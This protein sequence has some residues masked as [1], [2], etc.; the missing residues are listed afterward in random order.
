MNEFSRESRHALVVSTAPRVGRPGDVDTLDV[1]EIE[2]CMVGHRYS[3][4]P[5]LV[6][7]EGFSRPSAA[8]KARAGSRRARRGLRPNSASFGH[9][10]SATM[11]Q[12]SGAECTPDD[13]D[14]EPRIRIN[15]TELSL[16]AK[17][18]WTCPIC[19]SARPKGGNLNTP[20][21]TSIEGWNTTYVS[22]SSMA[23]TDLTAMDI[24]NVNS[25]RGD[26]GGSLKNDSLTQ[27]HDN[28]L[29]GNLSDLLL[30]IQN[31]LQILRTQNKEILPLRQDVQRLT[32]VVKD[33]AESINELKKS[34][35]DRDRYIVD[36]ESRVSQSNILSNMTYAD[37]IVKSKKD[38]ITRPN[39]LPKQPVSVSLDIEPKSLGQ[40]AKTQSGQREPS[41]RP[42][43][44]AVLS[45]RGNNV[46]G[47]SNDAAA[48]KQ[49]GSGTTE[50]RQKGSADEGWHL[51]Q[52]SR[53]RSSFT[54]VK[55]GGNTSSNLKG[56][57]ASVTVGLSEEPL[58]PVDAH[59]PP[60]AVRLRL[61][62][63]ARPASPAPAA[64]LAPSRDSF[65]KSWNF[66][67]ADFRSLYSAIAN[68]DWSDLYLIRD[69]NEAVDVLYSRLNKE[70]DKF[71]PK[72]GF[73][74]CKNKYI[75]PDW[76][77]ADL[78]KDIKMKGRL[79][80]EYKASGCKEDYLLFAKVRTRVKEK[81]HRDYSAYQDKL[82]REFAREPKSF[83]RFVKSRRK[84]SNKSRLEKDGT[85]LNDE[86]CAT[87]FARYFHSVYCDRAPELSASQASRAGGSEGAA[88]VHL[89]AL[90]PAAVRD[91]LRALAP[92]RAVGPD[93]IPP[94][95]VRDC[96]EVLAGP[97]C[98]IYNICLE[99]STYPDCWKLTRVIPVPKG[100]G[101]T[102]VKDYRPVAILSTF[103]KVFESALYKVIY[104]E[105]KGQ[106][107]DAQHGFRSGC[108]TTS[109]LLNFVTAITP[110]VDQRVQVDAAYFD[111][112]KAFDLVDNDVLLLKLA[113]AGC[114]PKTLEFFASYLIDRKQYVQCGN[115]YSDPYRT[116]SGVSQ[117]S[118]LGPLQFII[119]INDLPEVVQSSGCL[120]FAD[121]LKLFAP[122]SCQDD[123]I[124]FQQDINNVEEWSRENKLSFNGSKCC[125]ITFSRSK[126][127][128]QHQY[129]LGGS[130]MERVTSVR[131]LGV[132]MTSDLSFKEHITGVCK[133]AFKTLG[134]VLRTVRGFK[135]I[136]AIKALFNALVRSKLEFNAVVWAP[137]EV[138][139]S[140]MID[141]IQNKFIRF[142]YMKLYGVYPGY[143]LLYPTLF[144]LG[145]VGYNRLEVRRDLA[146][147]SYLFRIWR[148]KTGNPSILQQLRLTVPSNSLRSRKSRTFA[149]P[150]GRT[151]LLR[152]APVARAIHLLN[153]IDDRTDIHHCPLSEFTKV[154]LF[155]I[156]YG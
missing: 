53:K 25:I 41:N 140:S 99:S 74:A 14:D 117:G 33:M 134:F 55:K 130:P 113:R 112:C 56:G 142:L 13:E 63:P 7:A 34:L 148:G 66:Y 102:D 106:L 35:E 24:G 104:T 90:A 77:T 30:G 23:I 97:L 18:N 88:R 42:S 126:N 151:A 81:I 109:N 75:Y 43:F 58:V 9:D 47:S 20:I 95:L 143:P 72:K 92:K 38:N 89:Q 67:K 111:F 145:M 4:V 40:S 152:Q 79:H 70:I 137:S 49:T 52:N 141:K 76:Y 21:R 139:Y 65:C 155:V 12:T 8:V 46:A 150:C 129:T 133:Q 114:T 39:I 15:P 96:R 103:S 128:V 124:R 73:G 101:G 138:K 118:N 1:G 10:P 50:C 36:I 71:V 62:P 105:I 31:E 61:R 22:E 110:Q 16:E 154:A 68:I 27:L 136:T 144:V 82:Q 120:L 78:I 156:C 135:N 94:Y 93:G 3:R 17:D 32:N 48:S 60:L 84:S 64:P 45:S 146:L 87:E 122:I 86:E 54:E 153:R 2:V 149:A 51:V 115:H 28:L 131:D 57:I 19:I 59:H 107:S 80:K 5:C 37:T 6:P 119:L 116:L 108:S 132:R 121:D 85:A 98:H 100:S 91:A 29:D 26:R 83:W 125:V 69:A 44:S 147:T 11:G 123:Q 127:L